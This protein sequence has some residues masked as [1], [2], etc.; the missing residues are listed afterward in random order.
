[1]KAMISSSPHTIQ[2]MSP[3]PN[4]RFPRPGKSGSSDKSAIGLSS[5][6]LYLEFGTP[7]ADSRAF[8]AEVAERIFSQTTIEGWAFDIG[9]LALA[10]AG[11]YKTGIIPA[12]WIN[13]TRSHVRPFD[14]AP[15]LRDTCKVRANLRARKYSL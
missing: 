11:N 14:Y 3:T 5:P 9:V 8:R 10:R 15:V 13:D 12:Y 7:V 4:K 2:K 6:S 1:M